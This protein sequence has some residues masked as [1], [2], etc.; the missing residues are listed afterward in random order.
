MNDAIHNVADKQ[1]GGAINIGE[2]VNH[3]KTVETFAITIFSA[4]TI[5]SVGTLHITPSLNVNRSVQLSNKD[6]NP[7]VDL[8]N[9]DTAHRTIDVRSDV[10]V[11]NVNNQ[12]FG[13]MQQALEDL[14]RD[15]ARDAA[16]IEQKVDSLPTKDWVEK[17]ALQQQL[18]EI[19]KAA[20]KR[21]AVWGIAIPAV[22]TLVVFFLTRWLAK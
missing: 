3:W 22:V 5:S 11:I 13:K 6:G 7:V 4:A 10:R 15:V 17:T 9:T 18:S 2:P 8:A 1:D 20:N 21:I 12:D 16:R 14:K 19:N